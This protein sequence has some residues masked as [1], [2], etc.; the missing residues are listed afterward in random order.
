MFSKQTIW[1]KWG[2]RRFKILLN[3]VVLTQFQLGQFV[4]QMG[5][6][7]VQS[8]IVYD[9]L[10]LLLLMNQDKNNFFKKFISGILSFFLGVKI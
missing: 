10:S 2:R 9:S 1:I 6:S 5:I 8:G 4:D 3:Q 7:S